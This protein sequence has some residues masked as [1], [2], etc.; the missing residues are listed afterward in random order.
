VKGED[1]GLTRSALLKA[2][3]AAA[4]SFGVP[5]VAKAAGEAKDPLFYLHE[6]TYTPHLNTNFRLDH[7]HGPIT[8]EL[9]EITN[10]LRPKQ[11]RRKAAAGEEVFSL[12]FETTKG[13]PFLQGT[14]TLDHGK[15]GQFPLFLV[16]VG[17]GTRGHFVEGL[18]NRV[19][20]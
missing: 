18:V 5:A 8:V 14:Y 17:R 1:G 19:M 9:V 2:G 4:V 11:R 20:S 6:A 12:L 10:L 13:E 16:P 3:G 7:P 15:I